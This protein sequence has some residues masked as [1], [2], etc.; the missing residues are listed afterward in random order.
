MYKLSPKTHNK[1]P[2]KANHINVSNENN[3]NLEE[4]NNDLNNNDGN[5]NNLNNTGNKEDKSEKVFYIWK[6]ICSETHAHKPLKFVSYRII[7]IKIISNGVYPKIKMRYRYVTEG[8]G[9]GNKGL[10]CFLRIK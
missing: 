9:E 4:E 6:K 2:T 5:I 7:H 8:S 1:S 3:I 10:F